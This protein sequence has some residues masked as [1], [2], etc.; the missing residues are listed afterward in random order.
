MRIAGLAGFATYPT[1][2]PSPE[3]P[4]TVRDDTTEIV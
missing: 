2:A 4:L 3:P 1:P